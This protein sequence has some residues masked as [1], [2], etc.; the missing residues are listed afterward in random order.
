VRKTLDGLDKPS[1]DDTEIQTL[2]SRKLIVQ[3]P[4]TA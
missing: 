3:P 2:T 4:T 1:H